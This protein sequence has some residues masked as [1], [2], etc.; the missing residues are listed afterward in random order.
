MNLCERNSERGRTLTRRQRSCHSRRLPHPHARSLNPEPGVRQAIARDT[1]P[2][3]HHVLTVFGDEGAQWNRRNRSR[4]EGLGLHPT[5]G[6]EIN[7]I[8][9]VGNRILEDPSICVVI[10]RN[11]DL[12]H[13][14]VALTKPRLRLQMHQT[15]FFLPHL[16]ENRFSPG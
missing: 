7:R 9:G 11:H 6:V 8:E 2:R 4:L 10:Y 3:D 1:T 13:N 16:L 5:L 14:S 12:T 15:L